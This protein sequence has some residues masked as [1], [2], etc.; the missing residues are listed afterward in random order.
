MLKSRL[1][2]GISLYHLKKVNKI[3]I[4]GDDGGDETD[5]ISIMK[6]YCLANNVNSKDL[7]IDKKG[8]N[9]FNTIINSKNIFKIKKCILVTQDYHINRAIY[10]SNKLGI[11]TYGKIAENKNKVKLKYVLREYLANVKAFFQT[12][13]L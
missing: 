11:E 4:S 8:Y 10:V 13:N 2:A 6:K 7:L 1:D 12:I 3:L 9:T 5:E